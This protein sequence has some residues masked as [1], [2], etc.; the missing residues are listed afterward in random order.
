VICH[1]INYRTQNLLELTLSDSLSPVF[2]GCVFGLRALLA[3]ILEALPNA[4]INERSNSGHTGIYLACPYGHKEVVD[5]L[6]DNNVDTELE[7]GFFGTL[8]RVACFRCHLNVV[9]SFLER[10][11]ELK[12]PDS[13]SRA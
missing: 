1:H 13:L 2:V 10:I 9:Q 7:C 11:D 5:L 8:A 12:S 6:L 3:Y 4:D